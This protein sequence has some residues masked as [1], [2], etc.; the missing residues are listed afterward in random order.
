M[1]VY[2]PLQEIFHGVK[3]KRYNTITFKVDAKTL[4]EIIVLQAQGMSTRKILGYSS[5]PC[6]HCENV[7][8]IAYN[9]EDEEVKIPRG[10]LSKRI[11]TTHCGH[12][13]VEIADAIVLYEHEGD[14][15]TLTDWASQ[16]NVHRN[17]L[18]Y[19][20]NSGKDFSWVIEHFKKRNDAKSLTTKSKD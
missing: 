19:Q 14:K 13:K 2:N 15:K 17:A 6:K 7:S 5:T 4:K 9:R 16:L 20:I 18:L 11:P 12:N 1:A 3:I 8:V 10:I